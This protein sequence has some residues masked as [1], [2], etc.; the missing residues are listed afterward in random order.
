MMPAPYMYDASDNT[1][2]AVEYTLIE[3]SN[4][5]YLLSVTAD[6]TWINATDREFPVTI[7]PTIVPDTMLSD[8]YV[9]QSSP[10]TNYNVW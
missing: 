6:K 9:S 7:D 8:T 5:R 3:V 10:E 1:S 2:N 4:G